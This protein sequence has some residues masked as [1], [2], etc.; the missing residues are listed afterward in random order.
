MIE[1]QREAM[2]RQLAEYI[3][4]KRTDIPD[5]AVTVNDVAAAMGKSYEAARDQLLKLVEAG[6]LKRGI[7]HGR[8]YFYDFEP[9]ATASMPKKPQD[10]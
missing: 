3:Q 7:A 5:G 9:G 1:R 6:K 2:A 4:A 8:M 10:T